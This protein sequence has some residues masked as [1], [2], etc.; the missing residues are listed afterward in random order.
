MGTNAIDAIYQGTEKIYPSGPPVILEVEYDTPGDYSVDAPSGAVTVE[1]LICG[2]GGS[3]AVADSDCGG[4]HAGE[5]YH[6]TE[7]VDE[8]QTF[9]ITV[10]AGGVS[11]SASENTAGNDGE[12]SSIARGVITTTIAGGTG[13]SYG[14]PPGEENDY[15]G[16]GAAVDTPLGKRYDGLKASNDEAWGGQACLANGTDGYNGDNTE[17]TPDATMGAGSGAHFRSGTA[18]SGKGGDGYAKLIFKG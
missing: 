18:T 13:G 15:A 14:A 16:D 10:G 9:D 11:V 4:G 3:G 1:I 5:I 17:Q 8:G 7:D 6:V 2:G 12:D